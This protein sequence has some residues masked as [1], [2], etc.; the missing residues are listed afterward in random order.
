MK[1]NLKSKKEELLSENNT[2]AFAVCDEDIYYINL[3]DNGYVYS[4]NDDKAVFE[5]PCSSICF[6]G[7]TLVCVTDEGVYLV[8][9]KGAKKIKETENEIFITADE[10]NIYFLDNSETAVL[11]VYDYNGNY[12]SVDLY[13]Y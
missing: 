2:E 12:F 1:M 13:D 5:K 8:C 4:L 3:L 6:N 11:N 9:E 7:S 10:E